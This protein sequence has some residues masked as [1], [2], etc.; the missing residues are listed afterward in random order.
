MA[1]LARIAGWELSTR[2]PFPG[3]QVLWRDYAQLQATAHVAQAA[4]TLSQYKDPDQVLD[5]I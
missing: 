2:R 3:N 1:L 4:R 5:C